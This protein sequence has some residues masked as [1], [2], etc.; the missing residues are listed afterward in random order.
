[1]R[2]DGTAIAAHSS[3]YSGS[4]LAVARGIP[5]PSL[6]LFLRL[7]SSLTLYRIV[8]LLFF[9]ENFGFLDKA[10]IFARRWHRSRI[11]LSQGQKFTWTSYGTKNKA[12]CLSTRPPYPLTWTTSSK[13]IASRQFTAYNR[14]QLTPGFRVRES[15]LLSIFAFSNTPFNLFIGLL[16]CRNTLESFVY[17]SHLEPS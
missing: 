15:I 9:I 13:R 12:T 8:I 6:A 16:D 1:M 7:A 5:I 17:T 10:S 3:F 14:Y 11:A 4:L 2:H